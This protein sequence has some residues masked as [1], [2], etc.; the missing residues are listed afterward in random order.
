LLNRQKFSNPDLPRQIVFE[1]VF[2]PDECQKI[3]DLM[4]VENISSIDKTGKNIWVRERIL[5]CAKRA[6]DKYY[7]FK[8]SYLEELAI[9]KQ[10]A[11]E[12]NNWQ[13]DLNEEFPAR[14]IS[15]I[16]FL[17]DRNS[18]QDGQ[19]HF[20]VAEDNDNELIPMIQGSVVLF[21]SFQFYRNMPLLSG[22]KYS[23]TG[24]VYGDT[25]R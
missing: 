4:K 6:N 8:I 16:A 2:K 17:S 18:Y 9:I 20:D 10:S 19:I 14:K 5:N 21:P 25:F 11:G 3:I 7:R 23:L 12:I 22:E 1:G 15:I 13:I 24:W